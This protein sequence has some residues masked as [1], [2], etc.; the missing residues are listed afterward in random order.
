M[1]PNYDVPAVWFWAG[2]FTAFGLLF[3]ALLLRLWLRRVMRTSQRAASADRD[4]LLFDALHDQNL[5][6]RQSE[7]IKSEKEAELLRL[8]EIHATLL[9]HIPV[10]VI[11][12]DHQQRILFINDFLKQTFASSLDPIDHLLQQTAQ[13]NHGE[14]SFPAPHNLTFVFDCAALPNQ[15][16]LITL[17][18]VTRTRELEHQ[19]QLKRDLALMGEIATGITHE[20]KNALAVIQGYVQMLQVE[21]SP[22][23]LQ[24]IQQEIRR[25]L[26]CVKA[27]MQSAK[28]ETL[29]LTPLN[30]VTWFQEQQQRW[31]QLPEGETVSFHCQLEEGQI[32]ADTGMLT[33]LLDN[34]IRNALEAQAGQTEI[35]VDVYLCQQHNNLQLIVRDQGPGFADDVRHKLFVPFVSTKRDGHGLGLFQCRKLVLQHGG[36]I[37]LADDQPTRII[38]AFPLLTTGAQS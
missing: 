35:A 38:C 5:K 17:V 6:L 13:E 21:S 37:Q 4:D 23:H 11:L 7:A 34:L 2:V 9:A 31:I 19:L 12:L 24:A 8:S 36:S 18:N 29:E 28:N 14:Y 22:E 33:M 1:D 30:M 3:I 20:V 26:S 27:L 32:L 16:R 25:L 15:N 10:G